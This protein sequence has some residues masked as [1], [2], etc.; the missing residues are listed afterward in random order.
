MDLYRCDDCGHVQMLDVIDLEILFDS[1]YTYKPSA[2]S[3]LVKHF[4]IYAKSAIEKLG[5]T[6]SNCLDIGSN[7]GL[8]LSC[9]KK[10]SNSEVLGIDPAEAPCLY[11]NSQGINTLQ[12]FFNYD[13]SHK[14]KSQY[15]R[16]DIISANNVFAHNDDL[17][18]FAKGVSSLLKDDGI[19]CFEISYLVDIVEKCLLGTI[20]HEHL[21]HHALQP[22][23]PFLSKYNLHLFDCTHVNTQGGALICFARKGVGIELSPSLQALLENEVNLCTTT[24]SFM[25]L[26]KSNLINTRNRFNKYYNEYKNKGFELVG[27]GAARSM[28]F[29]T[30]FL[31]INNDLSFVIDDNPEK[32]GKYLYDTNTLITAFDASKLNSN[33]LVIPFAWIHTQSIIK[34]LTE[35]NISCSVLSLYP[36]VDVFNLNS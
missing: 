36:E 19:F 13:I 30:S 3:G 27:F 22:L 25:N 29:Y 2:N 14:I 10:N 33:T 15:G 20:F 11:A 5:Y 9:L 18:G 16:F 31:Q 26:F 32:C 7:D 24:S 23:L 28:N 21:S 8:F 34:R 4:D 17:N 1:S 12:S 35:S 6:P